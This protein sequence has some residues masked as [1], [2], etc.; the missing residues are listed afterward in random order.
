MLNMK[1]RAMDEMMER[2]KKGII[3]RPANRIQVYKLDLQ[4]FSSFTNREKYLVKKNLNK[5]TDKLC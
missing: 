5:V 1:T 3:L 2:I 4:R